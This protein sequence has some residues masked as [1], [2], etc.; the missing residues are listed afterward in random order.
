MRAGGEARLDDV[1]EQFLAYAKVEKGLS[2]NTIAAYGSDLRCF[3]ALLA[4]LNRIFIHQVQREQ[5]VAF[6]EERARD[7]ISAKSVHRALCA[8]RRYFLFA[9]KEGLIAINPADDIDLPRVEKRLPKAFLV[10]DIDEMLK[11]PEVQ[12]VRGMRDAAIIAVLYGAGLRVSE[13]SSLK[14]GDLDLLRG[15]LLTLGKGNKER[16][17]PLNERALSFIL[18]YL[19]H[20]RGHLLAGYESDLLFIR[21]GGAALSRQSIWKI[22]KK[23]ASLAGIKDLSP[24]KLR[25]SFATHLLEGGINL[26]ALQLLL[27]H[28]DLSTTEIYMSVDKKRLMLLYEKYH[29]RAQIKSVDEKDDC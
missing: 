24:H 5:V 20:G 29:P 9:R 28:A 6:C 12:R 22:I 27:G 23:Y 11:K 15:F 26:R 19:E 4:D 1:L 17:V 25:H 16:V 2:P 14:L 3:L 21:K 18:C 8:I 13:L 10:D 7:A